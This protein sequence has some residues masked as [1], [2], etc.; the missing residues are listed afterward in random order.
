[1][2]T[3]FSHR[4]HRLHLAFTLIEL[5]VV[6]GITVVLLALA[7]PI[8]GKAN[9][10][11]M[12]VDC[13]N[14]LRQLLMATNVYLGD[15]R[16]TYPVHYNDALASGDRVKQ[17]Y[18]PLIGY[19]NAP[20]QIAPYTTCYIQHSGYGVKKAPFFCMKNP[21]FKI[22]GQQAWTNYAMNLRLQGKKATSL[23]SPKVLFCDADYRNAPALWYVTNGPGSSEWSSY[24]PVHGRF[25]NFAFT[26]GRVE[27]VDVSAP[28]STLSADWF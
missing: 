11:R 4:P 17:W 28:S 21:S 9:D 2:N 12:N 25:S 22:S 6:M 24:I 1:M 15:H 5:L 19:P 3:L 26:D 18:L 7:F 13:V 10:N 27:A 16:M 23:S 14:N 8:L 20:Y